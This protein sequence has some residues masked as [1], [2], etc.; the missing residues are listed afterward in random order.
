MKLAW[1]KRVSDAFIDRVLLMANRLNCDANHVMACIAFETGKTFSPKVRNAMGS[2]ATG[3]IQ[4]MPS[5]AAMLG[6]T[7]DKLAAMDAV[8]QLDYVELYFKPF[9][10]RL[11]SLEDMYMA[12]LWP[13]AVGKPLQ[14]V[15]FNRATTGRDHIR[16]IQNA[17]LDYDGNGLITK[18]ECAAKLLAVYEEGLRP[19]NALVL[20]P[21]T[22]VFAESPVL[23]LPLIVWRGTMPRDSTEKRIASRVQMLLD[24]LNLYTG[25]I[26]G[27]A[28]N[29]T[30]EAFKKLT[31]HYLHGDPR[32]T[33]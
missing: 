3:L 4:F 27:W 6:T 5:T 12:I 28:G 29:K 32:E 21:A 19:Q 16:Y 18:Q 26:D 24:E 22:V 1:G 11:R 9:T 25:N 31:G 33:T 15:L 2:G 23:E 8:T 14:H 7:T 10:G 30:S 13:A 20:D 17:G